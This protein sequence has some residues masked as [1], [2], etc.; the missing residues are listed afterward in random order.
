[1]TLTPDLIEQAAT[2]LLARRASARQG[3]RLPA[4]CRPESLEDAWLI[5]QT[6]TRRLAQPIGGWK[7]SLPSPGK[8]VA[9]PIYG[10][11]VCQGADCT[12]PVLPG[13]SSVRS[14]RNWLLCWPPT[15]PPAP[16]P[17]QAPKS[18][19]PLGCS[20]GSRRIRSSE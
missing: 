3:P 7:T 14:S 9:A 1:M 2:E 5:Q 18:I 6:V 12:L 15:C 11:T 10:P 13:Q 20:P 17:I 8:Q 4:P 19:R 16:S